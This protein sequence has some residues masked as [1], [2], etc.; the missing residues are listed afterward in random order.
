MAITG[1]LASAGCSAAEETP[2]AA[3]PKPF[4]VSDQVSRTMDTL[5]TM[6]SVASALRFLEQDHQ[7]TITE[8]IALSEIPSPPFKEDRRAADYQRRL[9]ELGLENVRRDATGNVYG[10]R[11]GTG[12]GPT[13][14]VSA[15][16]DTVFPEGTDVK[17]TQRDGKLYGPGIADDANGLSAVL[18]VVRALRDSGIQTKGD[19]IFGGTV[20]EE[21]LGDLRGVKAFFAEN[22]DVDGFITIEPGDVKKVVYQATGSRRYKFSFTGPG[23]HSFGDFGRPSAIGA[24]GR[25]IARID[26]LRPPAQPKTTFT[27]GVVDGGTSV[28]AISG[29]ASMQVD[30]R[31]NG[32]AEL[33]GLERQ[34][35]P[36]AQAGADDENARWNAAAGKGITVKKELIGDRPAGD[37]PAQSPI[38]EASFAASTA[39]GLAASLGEASST[40]ANLPINKGIPAVR[41]G[42]GG[43]D[44][45]THSFTDPEWFD[46]K[47][48]HL[49]PQRVFLT[50][51]AL[52][53]AP[54][55]DPLLPQ[56]RP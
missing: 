35:V 45:N 11:R 39:L 53:G 49:G 47:D 24:M 51:L 55:L 29:T 46:P 7:N 25:A 5:K 23:G 32:P 19:I 14:F 3:A 31:S 50:A 17:V 22:P 1:I 28:N 34:L 44:G 36:M 8:Q 18:S 40:D 9:T 2:R 56:H 30:M 10:V 6:P 33:D 15:H 41:L 20:G 27:V 37:Q 42:G 13:L 38:V 54:G 26:E 52:T 43:D 4:A 16:L 21:G 12:G 48:S